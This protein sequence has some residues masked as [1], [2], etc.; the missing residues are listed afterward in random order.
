MNANL[1]RIESGPA[2]MDRTAT[3]EEARLADSTYMDKQEAEAL[4]DLYAS[5]ALR[6][7]RAIPLEKFSTDVLRSILSC[8]TARVTQAAW[9]DTDAGESAVEVLDD[10]YNDLEVL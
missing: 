2:W 8:L 3:T 1:E 9:K 10:L 5:P 4:A 7:I 6:A